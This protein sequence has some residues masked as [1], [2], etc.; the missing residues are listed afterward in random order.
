MKIRRI[1]AI[2]LRQFFL[3]KRGSRIV[4]IFYWSAIDLLLWGFI[5]KYLNEVGESGF[6]FMTVMLGAVILWNFLTRVQYGVTVAFLEDLW[7]RNFM[8][9][10]SS[11]LSMK[12]Y[13]GGLIVTSVLNALASIV[14]TVLLAWLIFGYNIFRMGLLLIPFVAILFIFGWAVGLFSTAIV[15]RFG[16]S[17]EIFAWSFPALF[18]PFSSVFYPISALPAAVQPVANLLPTA[19]V[20]EGMRAVLLYQSFDLWRLLLAAGLACMYFLL[21]YFFL[22]FTYHI[23]LRKGLFTRFLTD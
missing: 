9:L 8:N 19:H 21:A 3:M 17:A 6:N 2:F 13:V 14:F 20:F 16:P 15:M 4:N 11:P 7:A 12:E 22:I 1:Y 23:A 5:T 10:F 18:T